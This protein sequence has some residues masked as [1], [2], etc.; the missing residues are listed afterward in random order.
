VNNLYFLKLFNSQGVTV[1][2]N[3]PIN[4]LAQRLRSIAFA[5]PL[6]I[7]AACGGGGDNPPPATILSGTTAV[8]APIV[9]GTVNVTCAAGAALS[10]IP[11]TSA[12]GA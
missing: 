4:K 5:I 6:L 2:T 10:N 1:Q 8:G 9:G 3:R 11:A 12:M 7:L